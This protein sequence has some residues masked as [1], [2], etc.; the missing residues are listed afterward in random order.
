VVAKQFIFNWNHGWKNTEYEEDKRKSNTVTRRER[1]I[2]I[3]TAG[4]LDGGQKGRLPGGKGN[5]MQAKIIIHR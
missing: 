3:V 4:S 1:E 2:I 5:K